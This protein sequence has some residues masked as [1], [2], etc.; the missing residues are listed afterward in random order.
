[1]YLTFRYIGEH[2]FFSVKFCVV[3]VASVT[4]HTS[5]IDSILQKLIL[6]FVNNTPI[7]NAF[8]SISSLSV[9][10]ITIN[11]MNWQ[12]NFI[13]WVVWF[14]SV[15]HSTTEISFITHTATPL[16]KDE[17]FIGTNLVKPFAL[18]AIFG[19]KQ[20]TTTDLIYRELQKCSIIANIH[21]T[22]FIH[23]W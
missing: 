9:L 19:V 2:F 3:I 21:D 13:S 22:N 23:S 11:W 4:I 7:L 16:D 15:L 20:G 6:L 1:M 5:L 12:I 10:L 14:I 18:R 8:S 17:Y